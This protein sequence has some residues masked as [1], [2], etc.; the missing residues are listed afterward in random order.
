VGGDRQ[1]VLQLLHLHDVALHRHL[2]DLDVGEIGRAAGQLV[3]FAAGVADLEIGG[4][5]VG[6][7]RRC[8]RPRLLDRQVA[9]LDFLG[10]RRGGDE[11]QRE[12]RG[13]GVKTSHGCILSSLTNGGAA[14]TASR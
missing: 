4:A 6:P 11:R 14:F 8:A 3:G 10:E 2:V 9:R 5:D 7:L 12:R 1:A 13:D